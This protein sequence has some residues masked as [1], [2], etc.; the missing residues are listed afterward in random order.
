MMYKVGRASGWGL[1]QL[2]LHPP[3]PLLSACSVGAEEFADVMEA[4][5]AIRGHIR[6]DSPVPDICQLF[7]AVLDKWQTN[8]AF[9]LLSDA[10]FFFL[11][12]RCPPESSPHVEQ[13]LLVAKRLVD[14]HCDVILT[15]YLMRTIDS[16]PRETFLMT[17]ACSFLHSLPTVCY[18]TAIPLIIFV[19]QA[20]GDCRTGT[21][22]LIC[23]ADCDAATSQL[24]SLGLVIVDWFEG[25]LSLLSAGDHTEV[26]FAH[27]WGLATSHCYELFLR[28]VAALLRVA[29][30]HPRIFTQRFCLANVA[31][32]LA[33][34]LRV[35]GDGDGAR[36]LLL[37]FAQLTGLNSAAENALLLVNRSLLPRTVSF[38]GC[39]VT[40]FYLPCCSIIGNLVRSVK[41]F[42]SAAMKNNMICPLLDVYDTDMELLC[43]LA[44]A[45]LFAHSVVRLRRT[46]LPVFLEYRQ[47]I[48]DWPDF[49]EVAGD[50]DAA[51]LLECL[52]RLVDIEPGIAMVLIESG[53]IDTLNRLPERLEEHCPGILDMVRNYFAEFA[54][55]EH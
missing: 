6:S 8:A 11:L 48:E 46:V 25:Y 12:E 42:A 47:I 4:A 28:A 17:L 45:R 40:T 3:A 32:E 1:F 34:R 51:V 39:D 21:S 2:I 5:A 44:A 16:H 52:L 15:D 27:L 43:K 38:L 24:Y 33:A 55:N 30:R 7:H 35:F 29:D 14:C 36:L 50:T 26:V 31:G 37:L 19:L 13:V 23:L 22:D 41:R 49:L 20:H 18:T 53:I 9:F 54:D 10:S